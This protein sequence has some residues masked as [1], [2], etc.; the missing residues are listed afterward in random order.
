MLKYMKPRGKSFEKGRIVSN[1][2]RKKISD[3]KKGKASH[4]KGAILSDE[5][6]K[7]I[8]IAKKIY[9]QQNPEVRIIKSKMLK[10]K[11]Q[12]KDI[13]KKRSIANTGKKRS[14]DIRIKM[15][16]SAKRGMDSHFWKGGITSKNE[17]IRKSVEYKLWRES[18]FTRD[19]WTC[20]WCNI[21]GGKLNADHIKPFSL[22]PEL[23]FAIDNGRT[24][25]HDCHLKTDTYGGRIKKQ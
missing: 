8:S 11:K 7:R 19:E 21:K 10:G 2:I 18:V 3:S 1:E 17:L 20:V 13:V 16:N 14:I 25:C 5:T 9:F 15:R 4:R 12:N 22:F 24:L 6:K 23:R